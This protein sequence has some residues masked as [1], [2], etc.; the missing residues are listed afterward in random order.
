M[1][2]WLKCVAKVV[3]VLLIIVVLGWMVMTLWNW[4]L[5]A[6]FV[7]AR[8][9]DFPHA[10]GLLVLSRIL[11]GGFRG[12]GRGRWR[13]GRNCRHWERKWERM[14]PEERARFQKYAPPSAT[15]PGAAPS[16]DNR[17]EDF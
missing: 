2:F 4:V 16:P 5:P 1:K 7:G 6:L 17:T 9:I 14:T 12:R 10:F 15:P 8:T 13:E 11:F 3:L